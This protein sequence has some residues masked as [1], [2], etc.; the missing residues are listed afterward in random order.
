MSRPV[1]FFIPQEGGLV[2]PKLQQGIADML[3]ATV[4]YMGQDF[5]KYAQP[6]IGWD[7]AIRVRKKKAIYKLDMHSSGSGGYGCK[8]SRRCSL[9]Q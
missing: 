6:N 7:D 1:G 4:N 5:Q 3:P 9:L 2:D 8:C